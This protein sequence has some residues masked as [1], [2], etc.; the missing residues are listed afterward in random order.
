MMI[1][2]VYW[3]KIDKILDLKIKCVNLCGNLINYMKVDEG[4]VIL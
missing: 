1:D 4:V 3:F 2:W